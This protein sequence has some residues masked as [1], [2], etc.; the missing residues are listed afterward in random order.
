[1]R[2]RAIDTHYLSQSKNG[3]LIL[4]LI[5]WNDYLG[6]TASTMMQIMT[7]SLPL[8]RSRWSIHVWEALSAILLFYVS[9]EDGQ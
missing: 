8:Q 2:L 5:I 4:A 6:I 7:S 1:M 9:K 3:N